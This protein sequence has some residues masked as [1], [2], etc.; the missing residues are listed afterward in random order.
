VTI[1]AQPGEAPPVDEEPGERPGPTIVPPPPPPAP[2][3][4]PIDEDDG[5]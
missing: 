2:E 4:E 5:F 1:S 3:D